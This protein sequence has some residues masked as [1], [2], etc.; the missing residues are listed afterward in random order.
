LI[1]I[2]RSFR[3]LKVVAQILWVD[4]R[5]L[6][7]TPLLSKV[8]GQSLESICFEVSIVKKKFSD[9]I[10]GKVHPSLDTLNPFES[11]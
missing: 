3:T 11:I 2:E 10:D 5:S 1:S 9:E 8:K 7:L 6:V 4:M